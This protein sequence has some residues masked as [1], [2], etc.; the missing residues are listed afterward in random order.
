MVSGH[1]ERAGAHSISLNP[2]AHRGEM[3]KLP[4]SHEPVDHHRTSLPPWASY[5]IV[6][7]TAQ[8]TA[9]SQTT[10]PGLCVCVCPRP[11]PP[12]NQ[13]LLR[14]QTT[15]LS[16]YQKRQAK[17]AV[18]IP[19]NSMYN[20]H[21]PD[22]STSTV[23]VPMAEHSTEPKTQIRQ[24]DHSKISHHG[25][26]LKLS[27]HI[28]LHCTMLCCALPT[29]HHCTSLPTVAQ[30]T[31]RH[32]TQPN[33]T[34]ALLVLLPSLIHLPGLTLLFMEGLMRF[35]MGGDDV[36]WMDFVMRMRE[37]RRRKEGREG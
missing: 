5:C 34:R 20:S 26:K 30:Y 18:Q 35:E 37:E 29:D 9:P 6:V 4:E 8:N 33:P 3:L 12:P 36:A 31:P 17:P 24:P 22:Q 32:A 1:T 11:N 23:V 10:R 28:V 7:S 27:S 14:K 16:R 19:N 15:K 21:K 13:D 25:E 2:P